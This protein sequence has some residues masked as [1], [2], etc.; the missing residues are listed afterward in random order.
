ME[1]MRFTAYELPV[2]QDDLTTFSDGYFKNSL[3]LL[4]KDKIGMT[5]F[6]ILMIIIFF[7]LFGEYLSPHGYSKQNTAMR[8]LSPSSEYW[9]GTDQLGRDIFSRVCHGGRV[10]LFI[11]VVA[12]VFVSIFGVIYGS[13]SGYIGGKTDIIMMRI[14]EVCKG[15]HR[16]V[17]VILFSII[18][19]VKGVW[20]LIIA[21]TLTGWMNTAQIVRGQVIQ[22][23]Q[24]EFVLA[25][26]CLGAS[27][28]QI[29]FRHL[30]PN[31]WGVLIVSLTLV[32][33]YFIFEEAFLS[34][35]GIGLKE[36]EISWGTLISLARANFIHY[37]YQ[38]F[39]PSCAIS[40]AMIALNLFSNALKESF[41]PKL[42][43]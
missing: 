41:D 1:D 19:G 32:I 5:A 12:A 35:I 42:R 16:L 37:P 3:K 34:F 43:R 17:A 36:P 39:F 20:P 40:L 11:G 26:C 21:L 2:E 30:I 8:N 22:L 10:S 15:V 38:V 6:V 24:E 9:F 4:A 28:R 27:T 25:A 33:P 18:F 31:I 29:I 14:I 23:R 7:C 13:V